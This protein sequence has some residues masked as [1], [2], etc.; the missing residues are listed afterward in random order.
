MRL[1]RLLLAT[2]AVAALA[3]ADARAGAIRVSA[4]KAISGRTPF[5]HG[6]GVPGKPTFNSEAEPHVATDPR[7]PKHLIA[8][9][10]QDRFAVDGGALSDLVATSHDG[11][12]TWKTAKVPGASMCT[13]GT[14]ERTSDPWV[15]IGPDGTTYLGVLT[16]TEIPE[17]AGLAAPTQ[18]R[19]SRSVN[20]GR[21]FKTPATIADDNTYNDREALTADPKR[22]GT[23]YIGWVKRYGTLGESGINMFSRTTDGG[24]TWTDQA[25][26]NTPPSGTL[27]DPIV[28][29]V[30]PDGSLLDFFLQANL[31][32]FLPPG[33][34]IVPWNVMVM[35]SDDQGDSWSTPVKIAEIDNP[36]APADPDTGSQVRAYPEISP[37]IAPDGTA[38]VVWNEIYSDSRSRIIYSRSTDGGTHWSAPAAVAAP[39]SQAFIPSLAIARDGT[40]G[41]TWD[42]FTRDKPGDHKLT[43]VVRFAYSRDGGKS[44]LSRTIGGPFDILTASETA[45]TEI[46]GHF[47]G[48]YQGLTASGRGFVAVYAESKPGHRA[49]TSA[50]RV[51]GPS[52][53]LATRIRVGGHAGR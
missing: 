48:D 25:I 14:D 21:S 52:D 26:A 35:R 15:S 36:F 42:D 19:V 20:G 22:P 44:W 9:Y 17:L 53:I 30:L 1:R 41:V 12:R 3:P 43:T 11:G 38:Y 37:Q 47:V 2:F 29:R 28:I 34:P 45:S 5:P 6:C 10:Q 7:D 40:L 49:T 51:R 16:F 33:S 23:A 31:S 39:P 18:Q 4:P 27:P 8:T 32:P 24:R 46:A 13:G 50:P